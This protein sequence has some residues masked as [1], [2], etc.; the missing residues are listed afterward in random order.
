[1]HGNDTNMREVVV[2]VKKHNRGCLMQH[3]HMD[4]IVD[5]SRFAERV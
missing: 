5:R 4:N 3:E 2:G 1:M